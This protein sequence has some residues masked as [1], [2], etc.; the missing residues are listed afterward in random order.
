[1]DA[2]EPSINGLSALNLLKLSKYL[3][4]ATYETK[5]TETLAAF[6]TEILQH[7]YLYTT[8][9]EAIVGVRVGIPE[10]VVTD[11]S[12]PENDSV[13]GV[14]MKVKPGSWLEKRRGSPLDMKTVKSVMEQI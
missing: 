7:P 4:D 13:R 8:F 9:L 14:S 6:S 3:V 12:K 11:E 2:S 5:A 10:T 1:M